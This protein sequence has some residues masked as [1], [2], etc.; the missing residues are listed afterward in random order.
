[1][2]IGCKKI[3]EEYVLIYQHGDV[4]VLGQDVVMTAPTVHEALRS[5][6]DWHEK[7]HGTKTE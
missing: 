5:L 3:G 1:M 4:P 6:S 7:T 2:K